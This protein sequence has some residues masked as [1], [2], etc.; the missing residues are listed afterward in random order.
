[1]A[2]V[3]DSAYFLSWAS[4]K[5]QHGWR[6]TLTHTVNGDDWRFLFDRTVF[7]MGSCRRQM[8]REMLADRGLS[9]RPLFVGWMHDRFEHY[10]RISDDELDQVIAD[11]L[12]DLTP[13]ESRDTGARLRAKAAQVNAGK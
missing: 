1:L 6:A 4:E 13:A 2:S 5:G 11:M 7:R 3:T 9:I 8:M 10:V 12:G